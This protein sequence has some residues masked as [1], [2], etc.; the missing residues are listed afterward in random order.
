ML[1][2][3]AHTGS[4]CFSGRFSNG[5]RTKSGRLPAVEAPKSTPLQLK[6]SRRGSLDSNWEAAVCSSNRA[7]AEPELKA[8]TREADAQHATLGSHILGPITSEWVKTFTPSQT[9]SA[10]LPPSLRQAASSNLSSDR[11]LKIWK[12][13]NTFYP[14]HSESQ[15][16]QDYHRYLT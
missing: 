16:S 15:L 14:F 13:A 10:T 9:R 7:S 8:T 11:A 12:A 3:T 5:E 6:F 4:S 1:S 2:G